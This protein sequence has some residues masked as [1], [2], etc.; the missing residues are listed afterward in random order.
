MKD[1]ENIGN[2]MGRELQEETRRIEFI[3]TIFSLERDGLVKLS[4]ESN[5]RQP[6]KALGAK[7]N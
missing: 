1:V 2:E 4:T 6:R 3:C 7:K 5:G